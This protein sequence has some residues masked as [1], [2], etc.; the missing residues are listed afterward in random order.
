[1]PSFEQSYIRKIVNSFTIVIMDKLQKSTLT[2]EN[3]SNI[4]DRFDDFL[5]ILKLIRDD[6]NQCKQNLSNYHIRLFQK[7]L[8]EYNISLE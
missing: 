6:G 2:E 4:I 8:K 5:I 3:L 7:I 1:M